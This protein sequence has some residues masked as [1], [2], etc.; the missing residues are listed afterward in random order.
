LRSCLQQ[1]MSIAGILSGW[2]LLS[3]PIE[4]VPDGLAVSG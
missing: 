3:V 1:D 2:S 4:E